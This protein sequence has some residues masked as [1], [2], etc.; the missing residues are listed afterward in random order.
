MDKKQTQA[1]QRGPM[2]GGPVRMT[3]EKPKHFKK[4]LLKLWGVLKPH[5]ISI[6]ITIVLTIIA[7]IFSIISP[8]ILGNMTNQIVDDFISAKVYNAVQK[9][10]EDVQL[11]EG[12]TIAELP[13]TLHELAATGKLN[14]EQMQRIG[15]MDHDQNADDYSQVPEAQRELIENLDLSQ[16]PSFHYEIL[17]QIAAMLVI[18]YVISAIANYISGWIFAGITQ[19]IVYK[20]R[21]DLSAKINRLPISYFDKNQYGDVLS[22]VTNDVDTIGQSLNQAASQALSSVIML[23]GFLAMMF[24][25]SWQL[26]LIALIVL[27]MSFG[28]VAFITKRSQKHF[29]NQQ[30]RLGALNGHIEENYAGHTIVKA[31]GAEERMEKHFDEVN[32][33]LYESAWKSQFLSGL[34]MPIM[35]FISNLGYVA[36]AVAGGWLALNGRLSIGDIQAFIQYMSQFNQPIV[37]VGQIANLLQSTVAAAERVFDFLDEKEEV[38][39]KANVATLDQVRGEVEFENVRFSYEKGKVVIKKFS[40]H[41]KPGQKVAIVG[42]TGAGKTTIVNLLMRF[43]DPQ[44]GHIRIDGVDARDMKRADVRKMFGMVLQDTWL[45]SGTIADNLKYGDTSANVERI[46]SVAR[47]AHVNHFVK[48]LPQG[49][50]TILEEDNESVSMGEKQLLTIAR[51]MLADAPMLILDEATSSVDTRTEILIQNAMEK[52]TKGRT[53][54]VIAHRLSTIKNADVILV[55]KDGDIVEQGRHEDLL[56]KNGFYA[57]LYN[58]QFAGE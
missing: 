12:T 52:L 30:N 46:K 16:A 22:R 11:P 51:A 7:T 39:D 43:Y 55:M 31:F 3:A 45:F 19:K 50:S 6:G 53:S 27:P 20:L 5:K 23:V 1:K 33:R 8:K 44:K 47:A 56:A 2:G 25:I 24:S 18:L 21:R 29:K 38:S 10:L 37:Q 28:F 48:S 34:M 14:A 49:Y 35:H 15:E 57:E 41:I 58:A 42:P 9:N 54:F 4:S 17:G 40:A 13:E 26:T 36:T 32:G